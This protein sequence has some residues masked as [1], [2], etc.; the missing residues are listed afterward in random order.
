MP[1]PAS[2]AAYDRYAYVN[3]NPINFND[4]SG[5]MMTQGCGDGKSACSPSAQIKADYEYFRQRTDAKACQAGNKTYCSYAENH[6]VETA[7]FGL[8]GF[9]AVGLIPAAVESITVGS[10]IT[11]GTTATTFAET[12]NAVCGGDYC[13][14]E[15]R[16]ASKTAQSL[17]P[18]VQ[19][20]KRQTVASINTGTNVV[21][22][23]IENG[24]ARYYGITNNF[25]RRASEHLNS[26]GWIIEPIQGLESLRRYDA[27]FVEQVLIQTAG[28]PNLYNKINSIGALNIFYQEAIQRGTEILKVTD[29]L[30]K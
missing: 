23:Y 10:A 1:D 17:L 7:L 12:A 14:S 18:A 20:A 30:S 21:Y 4:P 28:L 16:G 29:I 8:V 11:T 27:R 24:V 3:N 26:R 22:Q 13:A 6:P 15:V 25:A 2:S 19:N 5:H 9:G